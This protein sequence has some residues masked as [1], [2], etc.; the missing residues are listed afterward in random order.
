MIRAGQ[1]STAVFG[2]FGIAIGR[3]RPALI[4]SLVVLAPI[5]AT[6]VPAFVAG[7]FWNK[8]S[9]DAVFVGTVLAALLGVYGTLGLFVEVWQSPTLST[10][11]NT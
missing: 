6:H 10:N 7:A 8:T 4:D 2:I 9:S 11:T 3:T 5:N 1:I